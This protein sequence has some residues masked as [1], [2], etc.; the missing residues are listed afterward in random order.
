MGLQT[1]IKKLVTYVSGS[2]GT[3]SPL[4]PAI[5]TDNEPTDTDLGIGSYTI[6]YRDTKDHVA[7]TDFEDRDGDGVGY[8]GEGDGTG[9]AE[10]WRFRSQFEINPNTTGAYPTSPGVYPGRNRKSKFS[11]KEASIYLADRSL[12]HTLTKVAPFKFSNFRGAL[13]FFLTFVR[14]K[15]ETMA[16]MTKVALCGGSCISCFTNLKCLTAIKRL[17]KCIACNCKR[18]VRIVVAV[19]VTVV[20]IIVAATNPA[21]TAAGIAAAGGITAA[22]MGVGTFWTF[23]NDKKR[24]YTFVY[25]RDA[26]F[27]VQVHGGYSTTGK[28][29]A[30]LQNPYQGIV[31]EVVSKEKQDIVFTGLRASN[32]GD[33]GIDVGSYSLRIQDVITKQFYDYSIWV[34]YEPTS[35]DFGIGTIPLG[36]TKIRLTKY[37]TL[38]SLA[39][40][41]TPS[42]NNAH[43]AW[44]GTVV[45]TSLSGS[46]F[47]AFEEAVTDCTNI[48]FRL[49]GTIFATTEPVNWRFSWRKLPPYQTGIVVTPTTLTP[50]GPWTL[51]T[52]LTFAKMVT[53][54]ITTNFDART[55][56][57]QLE[58]SSPT[59]SVVITNMISDGDED[60][61]PPINPGDIVPAYFNI[62]RNSDQYI[63]ELEKFTT[64]QTSK[65]ALAPS[66]TSVGRTHTYTV[67]LEYAASSC[68]SIEVEA[69][70]YDTNKD[71]SWWDYNAN[72]A[73]SVNASNLPTTDLMLTRRTTLPGNNAAN[74]GSK[75]SFTFIAAPGRVLTYVMRAKP[76]SALPTASLPNNGWMPEQYFYR[77]VDTST[78]PPTV[79]VVRNYEVFTL[80]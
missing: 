44:P 61:T 59:K 64:T 51:E 28:F 50:T 66:L 10:L 52:N 57:F 22:M 79:N 58:L 39:T 24:C 13:A 42:I 55:G 68:D 60:A 47:D 14:G 53:S 15:P 21:A 36:E 40:T 72:P 25:H 75:M 12:N 46:L 73:L 2:N 41:F 32:S 16:T 71:T 63:V 65:V 31:R 23:K 29:L 9:I 34:P 49:A 30:T 3:F 62:V 20:V 77:D 26:Q 7:I 11:L 4:A 43:W 1:Y 8:D 33:Q 56:T 19:V 48:T 74:T 78:T 70:Q 45:S 27:T 6:V 35:H 17:L 38:N 37:G 76:A 80:T 67:E 54:S 5:T 18:W 69:Y